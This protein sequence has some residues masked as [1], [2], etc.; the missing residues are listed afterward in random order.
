MSIAGDPIKGWCPG[1]LR[2]MESGDGLILRVRPRL[3][4]LSLVQLEALGRIA[5]C[6]GGGSLH[7]TNRANV[8]IRGVTAAG[9]GQALEVLAAANLIDSD[10]RTEAVRN[11]MLLP[12]TQSNGRAAIAEGLTAKLEHLLWKSEALYSLPGKFGIAVQAGCAIDTAAL[13]DVTFLVQEDRIAM[14]LE[15]APSRAAIF[16]GTR[17]TAEAFLRVAL[18]FLRMRN[19]NPAIRRMR[20]AVHCFGLEAIAN[21]ARLA[22][23]DHG[24]QLA[25]APAPLGDLA[26][27]FG[28]AFTFGEIEDAA[29]REIT[30]TMRQQSVPE[31]A[32]SP[33]RA[34]VFPVQEQ[35]KGAFE[36]LAQR[37]GGITGPGDLRLRVHACPGAPAC[38]R[39]TVPARRDAEA[40]LAALGG[41]WLPEGTIHISGCEKRCAYQSRADITAVGAEDGRY[42][43]TGPRGQTRAAIKGEGLAAVVADLAGAL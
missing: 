35:D 28:I 13:S 32:L 31:A 12:I 8:L 42:T 36:E 37:I 6:F 41:G 4:R 14:L 33:R 27:A 29:L 17:E 39:A 21:E 26:G 34:L 18:V 30:G 24:L 38:S 43:V 25:E 20:D 16:T 9:H 15:G 10:P 22:S 3:S 5:E 23:V 40:I 19:G 7:L 2:P 1:A 11:I